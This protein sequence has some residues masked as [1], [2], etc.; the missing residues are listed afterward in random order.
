MEVPVPP[1]ATPNGFV[2]V[3]EFRVAA[4]L[5]V[6]VVNAPVDGVVPPIGV[7]LSEANVALPVEVKVV[8]APVDGA[9]EPIGVLLMT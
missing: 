5:D 3:K 7:L 6:K 4:P 9:D 2:N 1:C 8:N